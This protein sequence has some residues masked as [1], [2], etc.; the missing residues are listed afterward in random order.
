MTDHQTARRLAALDQVLILTHRRPDGDTIG[1][2]SAL[3]LALR[4]LGKTAW[5]LPN[6]DAHGLFTPYME[7]VLAPAGFLP[8]HVVAVDVASLGMLPDSAG[9]YKDRIDLVIDH[10]GSNSGYAYETLVDDHAAAA[11]E[12]LT[13]LI[14]EMGAKITPEIASCLYTGVATDTGCFRFSN[15]T[16]ET[17]R[18]A[19][20]LIEAGAD[21]EK[22]N[23]RLFESRSHARVIAERMAL[24]SLEFYYDDR[25]ALI[26]LTWDQ[27]QA[28]GVA[29]AE[30]EDLT[31]LPRSIEGVEVGLTLRQQKD[32]SFKISVRTGHDT[33]AC[34]IARRLGGGGHPRAAGCEISGNPD[35]AKHA[36]LEE[37][38]KELDRV[39]AEKEAQ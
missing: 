36:I 22:L 14:P 27:I 21:V 34:N 31:S 2:A 35:N 18:A 25:C 28:A 12:L 13:T 8:Q 1:C 4:Q 7:G 24:E 16:A 6:E 11:A 32:G 37:V 19:A 33:N 9:A 38:K 30:L 20:A 3:C 26:C 15:T 5:V 29:G 23:E 10:H 39:D 17:H